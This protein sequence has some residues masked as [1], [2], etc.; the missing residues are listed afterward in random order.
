MR[1][2]FDTNILIHREEHELVPP[3]LQ[4]LIKLLNDNGAAIVVHPVSVSEIFKDKEAVR[5]RI[6][7]SKLGTY[8]RIKTPPNY[9]N[10]LSFCEAVGSTNRIN[11]INDCHLLFSIYKQA[12]SFLITEDKGL[13]S[14]SKRVNL[15]HLVFNIDEAYKYF[16]QY[17]DEKDISSLPS[18][19][20]LCPYNIKTNDSFFDSLRGAYPEFDSWWGKISEEERK[21]WVYQTPEGRLGAILILKIEDDLITTSP[22]LKKEKR[23]KICTLKVEATGSKIGE[24]FIKMAVDLAVSNSI[25]EIYVTCFANKQESLVY[26][27]QTYGF[28][29]KG[30]TDRGENVFVK[31]LIPP[32]CNFDTIKINTDYYP[33]ITA[34]SEVR[35]FIVP[36]VPKYHERLFTDY[37]EREATYSLLEYSGI[38]FT[39]GNTIKKAYLSNST[40]RKIRVNDIVIFYRS[41]DHKA[42]TSIGIVVDIRYDVFNPDVIANIV[43]NRTVYRESEVNL[44]SK[45]SNCV[46]VFQHH[47]HFKRPVRRPVLLKEGIIKASPQSITQISNDAFDS[48]CKLGK[49]DER[50]IIN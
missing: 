15:A 6:K 26:L 42:L 46:I 35:K 2:L 38:M 30:K 33:S 24:L 32:H 25:D 7:L 50:Y 5:R 28:M 16:A 45:K 49:L 1:V 43:G 14:R 22:I 48:I 41:K 9:I 44:I 8:A 29:D 27:I 47:F 3:N 18:I 40:T 17:Y 4:A 34:R 19:K 39:E 37:H 20:E 31:C 13:I 21:V 11:D 36:I 10:D 12:A 23:V